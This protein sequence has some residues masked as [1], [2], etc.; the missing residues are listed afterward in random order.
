MFSSTWLQH[1]AAA[2]ELVAK[3]P[4]SEW[5]LLRKASAE[6]VYVEVGGKFV[7]RLPTKVTA[8]MKAL[9]CL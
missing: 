9:P 1:L 3:Y 2:V 4:L 8:A 7:I 6:P 5:T